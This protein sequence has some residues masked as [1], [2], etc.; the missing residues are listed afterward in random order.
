MY[1]FSKAIQTMDV[2]TIVYKGKVWINGN[3]LPSLTLFWKDL[4]ESNEYPESFDWP[5]VFQTLYLH[6]CLKGKSDIAKWFQTTVFPY[7]DPIQQIALRQ[8][9]AYGKHLL[10]LRR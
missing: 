9:F 8:S 2:D 1:H 7:L 5:T 4:M 6:A 3:D 10:Q